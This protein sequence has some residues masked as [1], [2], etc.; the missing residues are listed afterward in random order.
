MDYSAA[1]IGY[2]EAS[3][4]LTAL[5]LIALTIYIIRRDRQLAETAKRQSETPKP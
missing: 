3:Y 5:C 4:A 1:H 2:V